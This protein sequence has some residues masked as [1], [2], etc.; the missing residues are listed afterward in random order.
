M[1][2]YDDF[3]KDTGIFTKEFSTIFGETHSYSKLVDLPSFLKEFAATLL[4]RGFQDMVGE[5]KKQDIGEFFNFQAGPM[6]HANGSN[7][8]TANM[9]EKKMVTIKNQGNAFEVEIQWKARRKIS[10][11][12]WF[13]FHMDLQNHTGKE[14]EVLEGNNKKILLSG[15]WEFRNKFIYKNNIMRKY[16]KK[17]PWVK[18]SEFLQKMYINHIYKKELAMDIAITE[19]KFCGLIKKQIEKYFS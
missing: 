6:E 17:T 10:D 19:E 2:F 4:D 1:A 14:V 18:N 9:Y 5:Q 8:R 11:Y 15:K 13:E 7:R 3:N 16:L 12:G